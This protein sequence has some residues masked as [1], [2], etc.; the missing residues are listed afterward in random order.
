MKL[1]ATLDPD[2]ARMLVE[3]LKKA[4]IYCESHVVTEES[5]VVATQLSVEESLYDV[6]CDAAEAWLGNLSDELARQ[7]NSVC[8]KCR[9]PHL[10]RIE[11]DS[12]EVA[13]RCKDCGCNIVALA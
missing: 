7:S 9:S 10:E 1:V 11:H 8:P 13:F 2:I 3:H 6:A 5:G 4:G 12:L